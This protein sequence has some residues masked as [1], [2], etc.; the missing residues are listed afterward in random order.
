[1]PPFRGYLDDGQVA[2]VVNFVRTNFGNRYT[3]VLSAEDVKKLRR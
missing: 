2:A 1:M 3:D